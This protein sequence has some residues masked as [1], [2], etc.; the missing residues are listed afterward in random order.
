MTETK[1]APVIP[2][3]VVPE[4]K[5]AGEYTD[6]NKIPVGYHK[7]TISHVAVVTPEDQFNSFNNYQYRLVLSFPQF[8]EEGKAPPGLFFNITVLVPEK[9]KDGEEI[10]GA[11]KCA[12]FPGGTSKAVK[13]LEAA[14]VAIVPGLEVTPELFINK[15]VAVS[16]GPHTNKK[17]DKVKIA[18][19]IV[20][21]SE[22]EEEITPPPKKTTVSTTKKAASKQDNNIYTSVLNGKFG[23]N[24]AKL[25]AAIKAKDEKF[26][27]LIPREGILIM[28]QNE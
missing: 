6:S 18:K 28:L 16:V 22:I 2:K 11:Y 21:L 14:G 13:V 27:G 15:E 7:A 20:S 26:Q 9:D 17:G 19:D 8:A 10:E 3:I 1:T 5:L 25:E 12:I 23:G 4:S 24:E